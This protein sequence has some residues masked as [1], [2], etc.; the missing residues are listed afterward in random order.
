MNPPNR[1][2]EQSPQ[3]RILPWKRNS[4]VNNLPENWCSNVFGNHKGQLWK[5]YI[6]SPLIS[7]G[8]KRYI[9]GFILKQKYSF[10]IISE[11]LLNDLMIFLKET[12]M[13]LLIACPLVFGTVLRSNSCWVSPHQR[14]EC[15]SGYDSNKLSRFMT[16]IIF[17]W[18]W[19]PILHLKWNTLTLGIW[20]E[21]TLATCFRLIYSHYFHRAALLLLVALLIYVYKCCVLRVIKYFVQYI[22]S[23]VYNIFDHPQ[24]VIDWE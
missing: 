18:A 12:V 16:C 17:K 5:L 19:L 23:K 15:S 13:L 24:K 3:Y 7:R 10:L 21:D 2:R 6:H 11:R 4:S 9:R 14:R 1:T 20:L 22:L 8:M